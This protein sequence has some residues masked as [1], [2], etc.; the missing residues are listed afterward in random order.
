VAYALE[1]SG[2]QSHA[3]EKALHSATTRVRAIDFEMSRHPPPSDK[4]CAHT[5]GAYRFA[6]QY[7]RLA[8]FQEQLGNFK[9]V[10]KANESALA[11]QPRVASYEAAIASALLT[12]GRIDEARTAVERGHAINPDDDNVREVRAR[13]DFMQERW[14]DATARFR[15]AALDEHSSIS[16]DYARCYLWLAQRRAGV[17]NPEV[18]APIPTK[19]AVTTGQDTLSPPEENW[20]ARIFDALRGDL[21]E[22]GLVSVIREG[23]VTGGPDG[24]DGRGLLSEALFYIGELRLAEGDTETARRYFASVVNLK[25]VNFVEYGMARAELQKMRGHDAAAN[26]ATAGTEAR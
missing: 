25:V 12:L 24:Y 18:P 6:E 17:R 20:P 26:A 22:D 9:A 8:T 23:R 16:K 5:L 2:T 19:T 15:L 4:D 1:L 11:C 10:L 7:A 21:N 3:R 13:L 14:A